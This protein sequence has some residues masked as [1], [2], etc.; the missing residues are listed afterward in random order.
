MIQIIIALLLALGIIS[1]PSDFYDMTPE[2]QNNSTEI[3]IDNVETIL[4]NGG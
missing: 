3:V 4:E 1:S 2:Q